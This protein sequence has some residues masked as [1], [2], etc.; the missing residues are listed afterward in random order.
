[1]SSPG[2]SGGPTALRIL[3]GSQLRRL[4]EG[5][6][7]SAQAAARAI[8]GSESKISRIELGRNAVREI[9]VADLLTLYGVTEAGER[10]QLLDKRPEVDRYLLAMERLCLEAADPRASTQVIEA[11]LEEMGGPA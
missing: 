2:L 4:R 6:G 1:M 9:D 7:I 10:E 3:L 5:R 11:I 8:R